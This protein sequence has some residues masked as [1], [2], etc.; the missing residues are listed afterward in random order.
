MIEL[1]II[2]KQKEKRISSWSD[3]GETQLCSTPHKSRHRRKRKKNKIVI[4]S[5]FINN[6]SNYKRIALIIVDIA[7]TSSTAHFCRAASLF[8]CLLLSTFSS[9]SIRSA[10]FLNCN[11]EIND[12]Q[13]WKNNK[14]KNEKHAQF[15]RLGIIRFYFLSSSTS[16]STM[17]LLTDKT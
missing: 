14:K 6:E 2:C 3:D 13:R 10:T 8:W 7:T 15:K 9:R 4:I 17:C 11:N 5:C 1:K 12:S 16:R